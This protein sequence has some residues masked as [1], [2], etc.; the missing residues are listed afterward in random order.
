MWQ[1]GPRGSS[2]Q[3]MH[4]RPTKPLD[5]MQ[6]TSTRSTGIYATGRVIKHGM[7]PPKGMGAHRAWEKELLNYIEFQVRGCKNTAG[8]IMTNIFS[9]AHNASACTFA[10]KST[11][12]D[13]NKIRGLLAKQLFKR[14]RRVP[15]FQCARAG[16]STET[17]RL[18]GVLLVQNGCEACQPLRWCHWLISPWNRAIKGTFPTISTL[19]DTL[20]KSKVPHQQPFRIY[21]NQAMVY[22]SCICD[23]VAWVCPTYGMSLKISREP[24]GTNTIRA[25][26]AKQLFKICR[27][28]S[29][30]KCARAGGSTETRRLSGVLLV[31]NGCKACQ[32]LRWCH[33]LISQWNIASTGTFPTISTLPD[34]LAKSKL[35]YQQPLWI[36]SHHALL[37]TSCIWEKVAWVGP[38]YGR[39]FKKSLEHAQC[40]L[41]GEYMTCVCMCTNSNPKPP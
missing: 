3:G 38:T 9:D 24:L 23:K 19:L 21:N 31:Q 17:R 2:A 20:A 10:N 30:S 4:A 22:T 14:C 33:L 40:M 25:L 12:S 39:P 26:L 8:T 13:T 36:Y 34:T 16:G 27:R 7:G 1:G 35:S 11:L 41:N 15:L 5:R 32:P 29:V 18:S 6:L 28:V 37:C